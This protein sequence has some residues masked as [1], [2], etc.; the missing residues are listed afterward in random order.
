MRGDPHFSFRRSL[1]FLILSILTKNKKQKF[2]R[3]KSQI[4]RFLGSRATEVFFLKLVCIVFQGL[5]HLKKR[6]HLQKFV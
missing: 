3:E 4:F 2:V 1:P 5:F 6:H